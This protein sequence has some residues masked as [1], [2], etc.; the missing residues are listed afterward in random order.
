MIPQTAKHLLSLV[1]VYNTLSQWGK[2][3]G[4]LLFLKTLLICVKVIIVKCYLY[5]CSE[6]SGC[7][8]LS[9][10]VLDA[11]ML[12][13]F[14]A[15]RGCLSHAHSRVEILLSLL[16]LVS[17]LEMFEDV[18]LKEKVCVFTHCVPCSPQNLIKRPNASFNSLSLAI[19]VH[20]HEHEHCNSF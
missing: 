15:R 7:G 13:C 17:H 9:A 5:T 18:W 4:G 11:L 1:N 16:I 2:C 8:I 3:F 19:M 12:D 20:Y 6:S 14:F 10:H